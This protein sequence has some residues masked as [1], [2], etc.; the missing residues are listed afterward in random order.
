MDAK[1]ITNWA[2]RF[3]SYDAPE[4]KQMRISGTCNGHPIFTSGVVRKIGELTYETKSGSHY[5]LSGPPEAG[6]AAYC[7]EHKI[8]L[9]PADPIK[10][11]AS[12]DEFQWRPGLHAESR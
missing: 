2:L 12:L 6:Y 8:E 10:F 5:Q 4:V 9:D 3:S 1:I 7:A 11:R